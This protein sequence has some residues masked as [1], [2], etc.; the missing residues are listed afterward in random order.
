MT[1]AIKRL[2]LAA[3]STGA[4]ALGVAAATQAPAP[5]PEKTSA[6]HLAASETYETATFAGGCYWCTEA[7]FD[8]VDGVVETTS[9]FM[10]GHTKNPT[11]K[12]V[13]YGETG[14]LE[15]VQL[16]YDPARVSYKKLVDY[17]W[18]T[19]DVL[20]GGG[21]FCDRGSSYRPAIFTHSPEQKKIAE[22]SKAALEA[23]KRFS[24]PIAVKIKDAS[25]F[26]AGPAYHQDYYK[27]N[28]IKIRLL[29]QGLRP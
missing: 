28:P 14:H 24:R 11:Y 2:T 27:K 9:G 22:E 23:S 7:D 8:K 1:Y 16:K 19:V 10:G 18:R 20:D 25:E 15:V 13:T 26:T 12:Q 17:Y 3:L 21:Q 6:R 4:L 29:P 5:A